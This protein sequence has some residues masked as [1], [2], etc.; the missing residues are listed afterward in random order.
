L[1]MDVNKVAAD[2]SFG[3]RNPN[4]GEVMPTML[5]VTREGIN[6]NDII[7]S[8]IDNLAFPFAGAFTGKPAPGL[9]ENVLVKCS[10]NS[11]LI[12]SLV[13]T[14][15]SEQILRDFKPANVEYAL[16]VHLTGKFKT[17]FPDGPP[18]DGSE[19]AAKGSSLKESTGDGEVVLVSDTDML[20]DKVCV[21]VQNVMGQRVARPA[22]G[23]LNFVQSLV[24]EFSGDDDLI[25]A[26]SRASMNRPFTRVKEMQ[27][28]AG[29]QWEEKVQVLE[30]QQ[31]ETE[32]K[33]SELQTHKDGADEQDQI[34]SPEQQAELENYQKTRNQVSRNLKQVRKNLRQDTDSME[35]WTKVVN[36]GAMPAV[37]AVSGI[38]LAFLKPRRG[39]AK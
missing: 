30:T 4:N 12:D 35:F 10:L 6:D 22:N 23:N 27:A 18:K 28:Q 19:P 5:M 17:A 31:R 32:R 1:N 38:F 39:A 9:K 7:T 29:R 15:A 11:Q 14:A 13:A 21:R 33:I 25:S 2:T 26:R 24:E 3:S 20:N 8:Q 36:I 37:V 34:L 16:A